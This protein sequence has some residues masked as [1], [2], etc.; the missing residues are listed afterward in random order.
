MQAAL[1][2]KTNSKL[3]L[4][5]LHVVKLCAGGFKTIGVF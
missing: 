5:L 2:R 3:S 4:V 1:V